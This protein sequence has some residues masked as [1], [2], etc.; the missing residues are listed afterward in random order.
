MSSSRVAK[1]Y[2][3]KRIRGKQTVRD[4][5]ILSNGVGRGL[6]PCTPQ[7]S[8]GFPLGGA[9]IEQQRQEL[10]RK[11]EGDK[12]KAAKKSVGKA[13][14]VS[15]GGNKT[16]KRK[17]APVSYGAAMDGASHIPGSLNPKNSKKA[18]NARVSPRASPRAGGAGKKPGA[19]GKS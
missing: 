9:E 16:R 14:D 10:K 18:K 15:S 4:Y 17:G 13:K 12:T 8:G 3:R 11:R 5:N 19:R 1:Q 2:Q 7:C 6:A